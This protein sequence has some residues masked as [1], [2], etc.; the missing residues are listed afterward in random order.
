MRERQV[1]LRRRRETLHSRRHLRDFQA[2]RSGRRVSCS[3]GGGAG[4]RLDGGQRCQLR[5]HLYSAA[6]LA[7][8]R[9]ARERASRHGRPA[10]RTRHRIPGLP[11]VLPLDRADGPLGGRRLRGPPGHPLLHDRQRGARLHRPLA[12]PAQGRAVPRT[13]IRRGQGGGPGRPR[14][15]RELPFD[16]VPEASF[17]RFLLLQRL[18]G[19]EE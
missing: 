12:W 16:R 6:T 18:S 2:R 13:A 19:I 11:G 5:P 8:R 15:L 4:L 7:A 3:A 1:H 14:Q 9:R 10:G 17:P